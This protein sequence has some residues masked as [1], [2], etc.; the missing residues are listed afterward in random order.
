MKKQIL[1]LTI[2]LIIT[3]NAT[4][5]G[6]ASGGATEVT[7]VMNKAELISSYA[8]QV[9]QY[10]NM[11]ERLRIQIQ[12]IQTYGIASLRPDQVAYYVDQVDRMAQINDEAMTAV[13]RKTDELEAY[14]RRHGYGDD[15][16]I[17]E[18]DIRNREAREKMQKARA[19]ALAQVGSNADVFKNRE[20]AR[21]E[22]QRIMDS[23]QHGTEKGLR[24]LAQLAEQQLDASDRQL[25][26]LGELV[27]LQAKQAAL[28]DEQET[29]DK[30]QQLR[31]LGFQMGPSHSK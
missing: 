3:S 19:R 22:I 12:D 16:T 7:Q 29:D 24:V 18:I 28:K 20:S 5:G 14:S 30:K 1:S 6:G 21:K 8:M 13:D 17:Q 25:A 26:L 31:A 23:D 27:S 9:S 4:A 11:V 15:L 10:R 2:A